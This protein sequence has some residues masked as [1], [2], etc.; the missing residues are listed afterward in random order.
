M[1]PPV[2][3]RILRNDLAQVY[4]HFGNPEI[5]VSASAVDEHDERALFDSTA[6][7]HAGTCMT[8]PGD[9]DISYM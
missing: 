3:A 2:Q 1:R 6:D 8:T 7:D 9:G 4:G 5:T